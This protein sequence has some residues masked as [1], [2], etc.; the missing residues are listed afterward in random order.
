MRRGGGGECGERVHRVRGGRRGGRRGGIGGIEP[1]TAVGCTFILP[2]DYPPYSTFAAKEK[3]GFLGWMGTPLE[4]DN[5]NPD[6]NP[7]PDPDP[8]PDPDH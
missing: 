8:D 4:D 3:R 5:P 7:N 1:K 2:R 6:H